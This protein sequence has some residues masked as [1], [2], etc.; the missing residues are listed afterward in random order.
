LRLVQLYDQHRL[1]KSH[2]RASRKG[3]WVTD[4]QDYPEAARHFLD[5]D[6]EAC[7][8][9]AYQLGAAIGAL[10]R[11]LLTQPS[12]TQLRKC[13]AILR[14]AEGQGAQALESVCQQA[15]K[16]DSVTYREIRTALDDLLAKRMAANQ[17]V[18]SAQSGYVRQAHE[19]LGQGGAYAN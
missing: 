8:T 12:L 1:V 11:R 2:V 9:R 10:V 5:W 17:A 18:L 13:Q 16:T 4:Q 15:L 6:T 14:L 19:F 7:C 3:Q